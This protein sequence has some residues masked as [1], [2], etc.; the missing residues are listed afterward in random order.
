MS[1]TNEKK[2]AKQPSSWKR[3]L[4][5]WA[6]ALG[7]SALSVLPTTGNAQ[8]SN[9]DDNR[10]DPVATVHVNDLPDVLGQRHSSSQRVA[11]AQKRT[12]ARTSR[13]VA[14]SHTMRQS[15]GPQQIEYQGKIYIKDSRLSRGVAPVF[16]GAYVDPTD[17]FANDSRATIHFIPRDPTIREHPSVSY[18]TAKYEQEHLSGVYAPNYYN[19]TYSSCGAGYGHGG[20]TAVDRTMEVVDGIGHIIHGIN[21]IVR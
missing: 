17:P 18:N 1:D 19:R 4:K 10:R 7:F 16:H 12:S 5:N 15:Y 9:R 21:Q 20:H 3:K 6:A 13:T 2:E 14:S 11:A 8:T